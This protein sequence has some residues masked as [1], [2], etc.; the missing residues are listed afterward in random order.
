MLSAVVLIVLAVGPGAAFKFPRPRG[1]FAR[2]KMASETAPKIQSE[3]R[4]LEQILDGWVLTE[5]YA[6]VVGNSSGPVFEYT[7]GNFSMHTV[8]E[9]ASTSKWP[10]AMMFAG[11]VDD[12]TVRSLDSLASDYVPWWSTDRFNDRKA[13][14]TVRQLL[15]FTSGFDDGEQAGGGS[16]NATT[17]MDNSTAFEFDDCARQIYNSTNMTGAPGETWSYN[18]VH[19]Q[20]MGAVAV[21]A[22]KLSIQQV[23][24]KY[25]FEPY[26]L[27][28]TTCDYGDKNPQ[29]AVCLQTTAAD[30]SK[31]LQSTLSASVLSQEIVTAS[32]VDATPFNRDGYQLYGLYGFGHFLECFDSSEGFTPACEAAM[33]HCDPGAFG[34]YPLIDR[35]NGYYM[36]IVAF[37]DGPFYPRSGIPEYLRLLAK[38]YVD[39]VMRGAQHSAWLFGHHNPEFNSVSMSDVNYIVNC[40]VNPDSC[41]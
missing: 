23:V 7:H 22:S 34:F 16:I 9:T 37:E 38:P 39:A 41:E 27:N 14:V 19:L 18:S 21:H 35:A 1:G 24:R 28:E 20:L 5:N 29:L 17:C 33:V 11:L 8:V 40:F 30:Y 32:E 26:N 13:N 10:I 3:W 36:E 4:A 12:G 25:L 6:V 2:Q 15:S 31:F